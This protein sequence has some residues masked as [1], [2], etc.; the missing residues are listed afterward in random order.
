M[1]D[2]TK[3]EG[4]PENLQKYENYKEQ[5]KRLD[6]RED[7]ESMLNSLKNGEDVNLEIDFDIDDFD[8]DDD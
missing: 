8:L 5:F 7:L 6:T 2:N 3:T 1:G 4:K